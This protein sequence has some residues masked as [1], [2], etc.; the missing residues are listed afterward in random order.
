M[1]SLIQ[2]QRNLEI[3]IRQYDSISANEI[4]IE[5]ISLCKTATKL[6]E[7]RNQLNAMECG[8]RTVLELLDT[9]ENKYMTCSQFQCLLSPFHK[10]LMSTAIVLD[11]LL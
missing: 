5:I 3:L 4:G 1:T 8:M 2:I 6:D 10:Q 9:A 11:N 7:V